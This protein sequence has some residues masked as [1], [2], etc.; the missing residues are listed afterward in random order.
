MLHPS[1]PDPDASPEGAARRQQLAA[2]VRNSPACLA[3]L[4]GSAHLVTVTNQRFRQLFGNRT[5]AGLRLREALP[6]LADQPF[7]DYLDA[8]YRTGETCHGYE[9][10]TFQDAAQAAPPGPVYFT[11][12]AQAVRDAAG[13]VSGLLLFAYNVSAHVRAQPGPGPGVPPASTARQLAIANQH[14]AVVNEELDVTNEELL[15]RN[16]ELRVS[17]ERLLGANHQLQVYLEEIRTQAEALRRSEHAVRQLNNDLALTNAGLV[18]TITDSLQ[19]TEFARAE[20]EA[21]RLR[22]HRLI[23]EAP[24]MIAVLIG[25]DHVVELANDDFRAMFGHRELVG[26]PYRQVASELADQP[27]FDQLDAVYRTGETYTG[28]DVPVTLDRTHSGQLEQLFATYIFQATRN[29]AG[30]IDGLLLFAYEV[31]EQVLARQERE[32]S[33]QQLASHN[34][35][36]GDT[37]E[38]LLV[39]NE[40]LGDTN[41]HLVRTNGDRDAFVYTASHDLQ[42][43]LNNLDGLLQALRE[44]LPASE[45]SAPV[46]QILELLHDS[47]ERFQH[48]LTNLSA[49]ARAQA[50]AGP[51]APSVPLADVVRDVLLDLALPLA[52]AGAQ[53]TVDV[54]DCPTITFAEKNLRSVVYNLLSNAVKYRH[55]DRVSEVRVQCRT[56]AHFWVLEVQD[57]GLGLAL[58]AGRPRF[59]LFQ[60][61]HTHVDGS[62]VGLYLV[63]K[64]LENDGGHLEVTSQ[65]GEGTTFALYFQR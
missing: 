44:E 35:E 26:R 13:A 32:A 40:T 38:E 46:A 28:T 50:E 20:A 49:I 33:H 45:R 36:L 31:T 8:V 15:T 24:A 10:L 51:P 17:N 14:L 42:G 7:F 4:A 63:Q 41:Q 22:L 16:D 43:P 3:S 54:A 37:N 52:E 12:V 30:H 6:E 2:L 27:F 57:N 39:Y 9:T 61:F 62:G 11:F 58:P 56:E 1:P 19:A 48:T 21:Q 65:L 64:L 25:P 18:D 29:S 23:A 34:A 60:R 47:V 55:P 53:F 5:L 59:G